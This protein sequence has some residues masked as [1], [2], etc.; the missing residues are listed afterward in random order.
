MSTE[1]NSLKSD[2]SLTETTITTTAPEQDANIA[3][4]NKES[5]IAK[6]KDELEAKI[7]EI[8]E[9]DEIIAS[10][11]KDIYEKERI[12]SE[13]ESE[14]VTKTGENAKLSIKSYLSGFLSQGK[15]E[16]STTSNKLS[17]TKHDPIN[18][19]PEQSSTVLPESSTGPTEGLWSAI[20]QAGG[21][22]VTPGAQQV[23]GAGVWPEEEGWGAEPDPF[24]GIGE[25]A[26]IPEQVNYDF[27]IIMTN[28]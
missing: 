26:P 3:E 21:P 20:Q 13:K 15:E 19:E 24:A 11:E 4:E 6:L 7:S 22:G 14:L 10:K 18:I 17:V 1:Y 9:K 5:E 8:A 28:L 25:A 27:N 16:E 2:P 23:S 12:I